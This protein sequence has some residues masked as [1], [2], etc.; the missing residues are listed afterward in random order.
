MIRP[1]HLSPLAAAGSTL[2]LSGQL[3]LGPDGRIAGDT[4]EEQTTLVLQRIAV[5]LAGEGLNLTDVVKTTVWLARVEDFP[6]FDAAYAARFG[7]HRPAR[8]TVRA[9]LVLPGALVEIEAVAVR[10]S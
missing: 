5:L 6:G 1:P 10:R 2:F 9:D 7:A 8:S 3:A 4:V